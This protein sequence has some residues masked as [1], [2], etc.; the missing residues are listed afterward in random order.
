MYQHLST[1]LIALKSIF[2]YFFNHFKVIIKQT[3]LG[4]AK[5]KVKKDVYQIH[6]G[7]LIASPFDT[8]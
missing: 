8:G 7:E 4:V 5:R 3:A 1:P 2:A 6:A